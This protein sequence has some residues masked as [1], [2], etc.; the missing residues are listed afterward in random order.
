M[1]MTCDIHMYVY[2]YA[3][4]IGKQKYALSSLICMMLKCNF[5]FFFRAALSAH[6]SFQARGQ[7]GDTDAG[8]RHKPQQ[9]W[10]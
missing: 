10:I 3:H 8:L 4:Q 2:I 1:Y 6:G 7:I 9:C 5:F